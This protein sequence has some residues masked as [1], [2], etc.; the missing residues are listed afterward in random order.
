[1]EIDITAMTDDCYDLRDYSASVA[2]RGEHAG[3]MTWNASNRET[4]FHFLNTR[5]E[6]AKARAYFREFGAW[7]DEELAEMTDKEINALLLQNIA[8]N[9]REYLDFESRGADEFK[10][11][12]ENNGGQIYRGDIEGSKDFG[13]LFFYMGS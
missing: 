11:W 6:L 9:L 7:S 3:R 12:N 2:E 4:H 1:M 8:G 10:K 13:K 5:E